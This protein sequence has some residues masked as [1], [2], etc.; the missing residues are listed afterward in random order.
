MRSEQRREVL[1]V[2]RFAYMVR[3]IEKTGKASEVTSTF[4]KP[5]AGHH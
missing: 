4:T 3:K 2:R 5:G 1:F